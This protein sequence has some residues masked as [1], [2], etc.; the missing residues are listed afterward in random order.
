MRTFRQH[1]NEGKELINLVKG[2]IPKVPFK[3][4]KVTSSGTILITGI[5]DI[6]KAKKAIKDVGKVVSSSKD[7]IE[8]D[9]E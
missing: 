1:L 4:V 8:M 6:S 3:A 5:K 9:I 7:S 2:L